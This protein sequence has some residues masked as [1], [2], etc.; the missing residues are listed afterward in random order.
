MR[1]LFIKFSLVL[2]FIVSLIPIHLEN[3]Q[4][5]FNINILLISSYTVTFGILLFFLVLIIFKERGSSLI[6]LFV[7]NK[8]LLLYCI[9]LVIGQTIGV[10]VVNHIHINSLLLAIAYSFTS[11]VVFTIIPYILH[12]YNY[13]QYFF[14]VI[15]TIGFTIAALGLY[16]SITGATELL[17]LQLRV[18]N[19]ISTSDYFETASIVGKMNIFGFI[20]TISFWI[21]LYFYKFGAKKRIYM[22]IALI[23]FAGIIVSWSRSMY[24]AL[25]L[26]IYLFFIP[27]KLKASTFL[28]TSLIIILITVIIGNLLIN[29]PW[30]M[31]IELGMSGRMY[32]WPSALRAMLDSP[33]SGY[34]F[35]PDANRIAIFNY[36]GHIW[37]N[38]LR[39]AHNG[40]IDIGLKGGAILT[41][42]YIIIMIR[43]I[44]QYIT[45]VFFTGKDIATV[46]FM[47]TLLLTATIATT[48]ISYSIGGISYGSLC[49]TLFF[50]IANINEYKHGKSNIFSN[51]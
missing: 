3:F 32:L 34:G 50:G 29:Y 22:I 30:L 25:I 39:G 8:L 12:K 2:L 42:L 37:K 15:L 43:T 40:Y 1:K 31:Q 26:G 20:V 41:V 19:T 18:K 24:I 21:S 13:T 14:K 44:K 7:V 10:L 28:I 5:N 46:R 36:G 27:R 51:Y 48:F 11:F 49:L 38:A 35:E 33:I 16:S 47:L 9:W 45:H 6:S 4:Y 17:G 23:C